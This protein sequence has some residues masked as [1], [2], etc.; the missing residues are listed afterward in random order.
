MSLCR[1]IVVFFLI[2]MR[3]KVFDGI[4]PADLEREESSSWHPRTVFLVAVI[5]IA[6]I[7]SLSFLYELFDFVSSSK[8][9]GSS[10]LF[11]DFSVVFEGDVLDS[12]RSEFVSNEHREIKACL[13]GRLDNSVYYLND[14]SFPEVIQA[15]A[16]HIVSVSCPQAALVDLHSHPLLECVASGV[17]REALV[18]LKQRNSDALMLIMCS[19]SRFAVV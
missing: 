18:S 9:E 10:L 7:F 5:L 15:N 11:G 19:L 8:V 3:D 6:L 14:V 12:L 13:F 4:N 17:D 16:L 1:S 2:G